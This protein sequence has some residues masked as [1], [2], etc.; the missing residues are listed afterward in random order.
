MNNKP[1]LH[2]RT[3]KLALLPLMMFAGLCS[4]QPTALIADRIID[5]NSGKVLQNSAIVVEGDKI[6]AVGGRDLIPDGATLIDLGNATLMP[7]MIDAHT[8]PL[9]ASGDYQSKHVWDD[10]LG[11]LE[12]GKLAD[13]IAIP[14]NPLD[15]ITLLEAVSFVMLGDKIIKAPNRPESVQGMLIR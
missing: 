14:G 8:H 6:I 4:A 3:R 2:Y 7:G 11:T 1:C 13:I 10:R 12:V 5:G 15:D 9:L